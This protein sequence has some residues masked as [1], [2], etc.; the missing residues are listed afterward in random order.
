V[1]QTTK[2]KVSIV[3]EEKWLAFL[4]LE[5][6]RT[7]SVVISKRESRNNVQMMK[8]QKRMRWVTK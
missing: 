3:R 6:V 2:R 1:T 4:M 5:T 8:A 7:T